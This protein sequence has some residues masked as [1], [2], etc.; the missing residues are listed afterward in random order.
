M[1]ALAVFFRY[2]GTTIRNGSDEPEMETDIMCGIAGFSLSKNS[3]INSKKLSNALLCGIESRGNQAAGYA[4][5]D[6]V[7]SGV[8]KSN[9]RGSNLS[10][11][12]MPRD[13]DTVILHTRYATHG[14]VKV[15]ANNH[16]V[17]SPDSN[18][19]LVHNG[20]IYN[21][22]RVRKELPYTLPEVDTSVI[23]A[24]LQKYG[25]D[26]LDMLDGDASIAWL[27]E[28]ENGTL[29][30]GRFSHSPLYV[31]QTS[32]GSLVFAS[33]ETILLDALKRVRVDVVYL[34][35]VPEKVLYTVRQGRIDGSDVMPETSPE[36]EEKLSYSS[37]GKYRGM[38]SGGKSVAGYGYADG[39]D[40]ASDLYE[41]LDSEDFQEFLTNYYETDGFF[42]DYSGT[43]L[44]DME[45]MR[46]IFEDYR[47]NE[48]WMD[49]DKNYNPWTF[50]EGTAKNYEALRRVQPQPFYW[51]DSEIF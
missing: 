44:G 50:T 40:Y 28:R 7:S 35:Q 29:R 49:K 38:T 17:M 26:R 51:N 9:V 30:V 2:T 11:K 4:W 19:A 27:D 32:D 6:G 14:S 41:E 21:H 42:Y 10:L 22:N 46:D 48:Y 43:F 31:A 8:Y 37:Y 23:P 45:S 39:L 12:G 20:V 16:P 5:Q 36:F 47:Y 34:Q 3:K 25:V 24:I 18:I 15:M 33:T 1:L 13:A